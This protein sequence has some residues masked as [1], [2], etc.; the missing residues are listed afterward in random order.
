MTLH[1]VGVGVIWGWSRRAALHAHAH[2]EF[3][4]RETPRCPGKKV[5]AVY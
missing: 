2:A 5:V 1:R 4:G 3:L